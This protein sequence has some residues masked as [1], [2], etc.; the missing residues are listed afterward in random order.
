MKAA[1]ASSFLKTDAINS[2]RNITVPDKLKNPSNEAFQISS[3]AKEHFK[4][5]K[6]TV[7]RKIIDG[8]FVLPQPEITKT[9]QGTSCWQNGF[10]LVL[11]E[12]NG[13]EASGSGG[14]S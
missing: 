5:E 8:S 12:N 4:L 13:V 11:E 6:E 1:I 9:K 14:Y 7:Y 2:L 10:L 3:K